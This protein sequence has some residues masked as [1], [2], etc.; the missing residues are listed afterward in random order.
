MKTLREPA[1]IVAR[2]RQLNDMVKFCTN[3]NHFGVVTIDPTFCL[4]DFEV[5][6]TTCRHLV[7]QCRRSSEPPVFIGPAMVHYKKTFST[8]LFFAFS[9][10]GLRPDLSKLKCFGTDGEEGLYTAFKQACPE[11]I[12][13]LCSLHCRRNIKDKLRE[14]QVGGDKQEIV[15]ADIFGKQFGSQQVEGL[16]DSE[17]EKEFE[18]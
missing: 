1:V 18:L 16:I 11:A 13:L 14:L 15:L 12:H 7:L 10:I 8:Y 5:T 3:E 2:D 4:G 17:D 9:L 6:I